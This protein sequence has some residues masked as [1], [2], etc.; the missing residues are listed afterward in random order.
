[1]HYA[2]GQYGSVLKLAGSEEHWKTPATSFRHPPAHNESNRPPHVQSLAPLGGSQRD[3]ELNRADAGTLM[4]AGPRFKV[5]PLLAA[6]T[7]FVLTLR[8]ALTLAVMPM[9]ALPTLFVV[10]LL[11]QHAII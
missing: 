2:Y 7:W 11:L 10:V 8:A 9:P 3:I 4:V 6:L 1:M 5:L